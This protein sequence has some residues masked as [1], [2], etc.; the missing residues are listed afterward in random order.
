MYRCPQRAH[1]CFVSRQEVMPL[2]KLSPLGESE[3][4]FLVSL[5]T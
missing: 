4:E 5:I 1:D 3:I 2:G